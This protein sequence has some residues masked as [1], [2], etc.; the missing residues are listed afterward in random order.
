[1]PL[2]SSSLLGRTLL[3]VGVAGIIILAV[4]HFAL[5]T[6]NIATVAIAAVLLIA[7]AA[8]SIKS[9]VVSRLNELDTY[10]HLVISTETAPS[11]PL[12][13]PGSDELA[14]ISNT[15]NSF[16]E[17]LRDVMTNI[18]SDANGVLQ[19]AEDQTQRMSNSVAQLETSSSEALNIAESIGQIADTSSTLS[20]NAGQIASTIGEALESLELGSD[21]SNANQ[22]SMKE[23]VNNVELMSE[24]IARLQE[25]SAQIGSVLDVIGGIAEQTNLLALNAA[26]E[27]ARAGEQ[28]RGFAVVADEVRALA[29]RTQDSTGEIQTM[30]EGLQDK[31]QSAVQ[32]MEQGRLLSSNSLEQS[33]Q[34]ESV[35]QQ[36]QSVV[37]NVDGLATQIAEGTTIQNNATDSIN[38]QMSSIASQIREVSAGL[39][40]ISEKAHDQQDI[41]NKVDSELNKICV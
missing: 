2:F 3:P 19:G 40:I 30:V 5:E 37:A 12:Q 4:I 16:I 9:Q 13:D 41:A 26:I 15:L 11:N 39:G 17:N 6:I 22:S 21:A 36:V 33:Q 31:A 14:T 10:L 27:A 20:D 28:G 18:R 35:L 29:H 32:A 34:V 23:L 24:N 7:V 38:Q 1:M 25:E 8:W